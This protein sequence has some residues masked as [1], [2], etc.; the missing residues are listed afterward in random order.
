ITAAQVA[1]AYKMDV[2]K[3]KKYNDFGSDVIPAN[4]KVYFQ[5]KRNKGPFGL[6]THIVQRGE[7]MSSISQLYGIKLK[8]LYHRNRMDMNQ[9]QQA[10]VGQELRLRGKRSSAPV[11]STTPIKPPTNTDK[12]IFVP[13]SSTDDEENLND[14]EIQPP[15]VNPPNTDED[16]NLPIFPPK[17]T[18][19]PNTVTHIVKKGD[20]L[21]KISRQYNVSVA[22]IK[23][24]NGMTSNDLKVGQS[25]KIK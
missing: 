6:K 4:N 5:P 1:R 14:F 24:A 17:D 8:C 15:V 2:K 10:A 20:T 7:T 18:D 23:A 12:P 13:N 16:G 11:L 9:Q 3:L 19:N 22:V 25:L 21:Y